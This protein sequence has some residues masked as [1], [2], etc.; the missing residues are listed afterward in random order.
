MRYN[1][2]TTAIVIVVALLFGPS[3]AF[4]TITPSGR[5]TQIVTYT[6]SNMA[7][8]SGPQPYAAC[9]APAGEYAFDTSTVLGKQILSLIVAAHLSGRTI[10]FSVNGCV[11]VWGTNY[12]II[13][14]VLL[15]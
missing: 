3:L 15:Q 6:S 7:R 13:D 11:N 2:H 9:G 1:T 4:A 12:P 14:A 8:I 5:T 10:L